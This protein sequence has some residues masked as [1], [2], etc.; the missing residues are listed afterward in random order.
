M[1]IPLKS[2]SIANPLQS[3]DPAEGVPRYYALPDASDWQ[4]DGCWEGQTGGPTT[5]SQNRKGPTLGRAFK[6]PLQQKTL[7]RFQP[8]G[9]R[10]IAKR[11]QA[12]QAG[13]LHL[14]IFQLGQAFA[15]GLKAGV[16][17]G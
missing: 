11:V 14:E 9:S 10:V 8:L 16:R 1:N 15:D 13:G 5:S 6:L 2:L 3:P 4:V 12:G 7:D 17:L